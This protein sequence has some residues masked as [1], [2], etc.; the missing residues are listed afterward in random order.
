[1]CNRKLCGYDVNGWRDGVAR[2][3]VARPGDEEE[4]G[5]LRI[6]EG[7][8]LPEV[9]HVGTDPDSRWIGG[10]Q[11]DLAPHGR[12]GGWGRIG[13]P[14]LRKTVWSMIHDQTTSPDMFA[15]AFTGLAQGAS[16][17]VVA[18]D[19]T[20]RTTESMQ[21]RLF[22]ALSTARAGKSLLV[23]RSVLSVL[24]ALDAETL[25]GAARDGA[26]LGIIG[27]VADGF[28]V[29]ILRMRVER[30]GSEQ[31]LAPERRQV[32][33]LVSSSFGYEGLVRAATAQIMALAP[34]SRADH[35]R[36][37]RAIGRLAFGL[38]VAPEP[39]RR[40]NGDWDILDPPDEL[41]FPQSDLDQSLSVPLQDCDMILFESLTEGAVRRMLLKH[42]R[43]ALAKPLTALPAT[44]V[45]KGALV[46]AKRYATGKTVY[47]DFLPRIATI[48]QGAEGAVSHDLIDD[49][50]TLPAGSLYRS[51]QPARLAL[52][53]GQDRFQV[54]LRKETHKE[55][56][57]AVVEVGAQ[58]QKMA[59]VD[60]WVEQVPAA[61]RARILIQAPT[62]S[63]QFTVDWE[64]AEVQDRTWEEILADLATPP[65][66]IPQRLVLPCG[67][68]A[69]H[70]STRGPG[71]LALL[72]DNVG[73][74]APDWDALA[75]KLAARPLGEYC[76]SSD[77]T[78]PAEVPAEA[79]DQLA[80]LTARA[81]TA[82]SRMIRGT[83][84]ADTGP[85]RF[86][87]W[88]FRRCPVDLAVMLLDAWK[89]RTA[90]GAHPFATS[91]AAWILIRQGLG[92]IVSDPEHERQAIDLLQQ[93]PLQS[94]SWR[95]ET[96]AA[97]FLLS[98]SDDCPMLL[99]RD[100]VERLGRRTIEEFDANLGTE[101]TK[102]QYAPFLLVGLLR[103]R[104]KS[105][106]AL[107][108]GSDRLADQ[109]SEAVK[110]VINDMD[111]RAGRTHKMR[112]IADRWL[113]LLSDVLHELR[114]TGKNPDLLSAIYDG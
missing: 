70:D 25:K 19:D 112:R 96:A 57:K 14:E 79:L 80:D 41:A 61:G 76:I 88:Q 15:A 95:E 78:V 7:A 47:F 34:D 51:P 69:W 39:L 58:S 109:L 85:L 9:V 20:E 107:V 53:A 104:L 5:V 75:A 87:T 101:Y 83:L 105:P 59:P 98:R 73:R 44:A 18:I 100:A 89:I 23:W 49:A 111:R 12:G 65:P 32:G 45:A 33:Q 64:A 17:S 81:V 113:P 102:F 71:L 94:W 26:R 10:A 68:G 46:A 114:G 30:H 16:H 48:I 92:R 93:M 31:H 77:G 82:L 21:E 29:Q 52:A 90:G 22:A 28:S 60:L 40:P 54:Y 8:V 91:P 84:P 108:E 86:L 63:R 43:A 50:E 97:A 4:I 3:W 66:T 11:A 55:P 13:A 74:S 56:R 35:F 36:S 99:D 27:H 72:E 42:L 6:V 37:A 2:N 103:W 67:M 1:M 38:K 24:H 106:R 110:R 62:L